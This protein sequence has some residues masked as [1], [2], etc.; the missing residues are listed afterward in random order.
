MARWSCW[1]HEL[2]GSVLILPSACELRAFARI[3]CT[4]RSTAGGVV[5]GRCPRR[6]REPFNNLGSW[7]R[8]GLALSTR[9]RPELLEHWPGTR[10]SF[11]PVHSAIE[12]TLCRC[13]P[14][15]PAPGQCVK[16][17]E[18]HGCNSEKGGIASRRIFLSRPA[19]VRSMPW[20]FPCPSCGP[21]PL[22]WR[23]IA[24]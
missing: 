1:R 17:I 3:C 11:H 23:A 21:Q 7:L 22:R 15:S 10:L 24:H 16:M 18:G 12:G 6:R 4:F 13:A 5:A 19:G 8:G 14:P 9:L 20:S 2:C